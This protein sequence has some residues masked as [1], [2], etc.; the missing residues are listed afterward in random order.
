MTKRR[1]KKWQKKLLK[2]LDDF[3]LENLYI[4]APSRVE[5]ELHH[6]RDE[7]IQ[8]KIDKELSWKY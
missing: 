7:F 4:N 8:L 1:Y 2:R 3:D 6:L 5:I